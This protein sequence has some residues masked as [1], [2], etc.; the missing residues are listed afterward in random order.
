MSV[1]EILFRWL[2]S[3]LAIGAQA[4]YRIAQARDGI[5]GRTAMLPLSLPLQWRAPWQTV[6]LLSWCAGTLL[7]PTWWGTGVLLLIDAHSDHPFFWPLT[8]AVVAI[9]NAVAIAW[10]NQR[11]HRR[12]FAGRVSLALHYFKVGALAGG[13]LLLLLGW[14]TGALQDF[15]GPMASTSGAAI[16]ALL[17]ALSW[18]LLVAGIFSVLSFAHAAVLHA[19]LAFEAPDQIQRQWESR[20]KP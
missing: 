9:A 6:Q 14:G 20:R 10:T 4:A 7:A 16:G 5:R 12:P 3:M 15:A 1:A 8:M 2:T 11:H 17:A 13:I 18:S 19:W